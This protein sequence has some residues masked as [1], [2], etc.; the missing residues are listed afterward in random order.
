MKKVLIVMIPIIIVILI[1]VVYLVYEKTVNA[2]S[3]NNKHEDSYSSS[4]SGKDDIEK[5]SGT[6]RVEKV[7]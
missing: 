4:N 2:N 7:D 1:G 3:E 5:L 6:I